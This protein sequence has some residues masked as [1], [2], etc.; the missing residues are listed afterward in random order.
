M[1]LA[2]SLSL[3][4]PAE[5]KGTPGCE[6]SFVT[7]VWLYNEMQNVRRGILS[8]ASCIAW[9]CLEETENQALRACGF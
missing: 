9:Q 8:R 5:Q 4:D 2:F 3:N 6:K 1:Q 7:N